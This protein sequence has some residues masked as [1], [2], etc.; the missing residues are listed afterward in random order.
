MARCLEEEHWHHFKLDKTTRFVYENCNE[1]F[2]KRF[3]N[4]LASCIVSLDLDLDRVFVIVVDDEH[5]EFLR[6]GLAELGITGVNIASTYYSVIATNIPKED[7]ATTHKFSCL[8]RN[9]RPWRL[10]FFANL[11]NDNLIK[12][13]VFTF[14]NIFPYGIIKKFPLSELRMDLFN[15]GIDTAQ[16]PLNSW[17]NG[18]PYDL[19]ARVDLKFHMATYRAIQQ[20]DINIIIESQFNPNEYVR[21][22]AYDSKFQP[23]FLTEKTFK[24][25]ACNRPF[26]S[27]GV[28]Y[29]LACIRRMGFK[30]FEGLIDESYDT[31]VDNE[32][33]HRAVIAEITRIA[34]LDKDAYDSLIADCK[35]IAEYNLSMLKTLQTNAEWTNNNFPKFTWLSD[36]FE[37]ETQR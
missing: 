35:E 23:I 29:T 11:V 22:R 27:Y 13:F 15:Y 10:R 37:L 24:A 6:N 12:D 16:E 34:A 25:I 20:A 18:I 3:V 19:D 7:T 17:I 9:Y 28:P 5:A 1:T 2:D 21:S 8:S 14:H 4:S 31:I 26:I 33:R 30:T 36:A 32:T